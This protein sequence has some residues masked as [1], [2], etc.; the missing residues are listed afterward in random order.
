MTLLSK[1]ISYPESF[2]AIEHGFTCLFWHYMQYLS[3][4]NWYSFNTKF[5]FK[6]TGE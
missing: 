3:I 2:L 4:C 6:F 1:Q 5:N